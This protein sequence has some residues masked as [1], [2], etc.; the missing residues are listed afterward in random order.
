MV[1]S[2][3]LRQELTSNILDYIKRQGMPA[4]SRLTEKALCD[5][6]NVSRTPVRAALEMLAGDGVIRHVHNKGYFTDVAAE[7]IDTEPAPESDEE[8]LYLRLTRDRFAGD[9]ANEFTEADLMRRYSVPRRTLMR[10]LHRLIREMLV[11]KRP[12]RGW[13]FADILD[14]E[15]AHDESYRYRLCIEPAA[16]LEPTFAADPARLAQSQLAHE[17]ILAGRAESVS[18]VAFFQMNAD[19]HQMLADFSGN[20]FFQEAMRRQNNLRRII[21]YQWVYGPERVIE[22]CQEHLAII[23]AVNSGDRMWAANLLRKH[24][25]SAAEISPYSES[26]DETDPWHIEVTRKQRRKNA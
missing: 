19:F 5:E 6:F 3:K 24:I 7:A 25:S 23:E 22:T 21:S 4:G 1:P 8:L 16:L 14:S 10:V 20:R 13:S 18:S 2:N 9:L 15:R 11:E 26:G 17:E 12:G